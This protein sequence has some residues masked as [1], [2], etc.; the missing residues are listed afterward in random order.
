MAARG[1]R[2]RAAVLQEDPDHPTPGRRALTASGIPVL[3]F[4]PAGSVAA[5]DNVA[6]LLGYVDDDPPAAILL[7][8]VIPVYRV[9]IADGLFDVP[10]FDVSPGAMSFDALERY[11]ERPRPELPY[12][13]AGDYAARLKAA[14]VKYPAEAARAAA[15]L[16]CPVHVIPNGVPINAT[17]RRP[18][19]ARIVIGTVARIHPTKRL[20]LL[21]DAMKRAHRSLPPYVLRIAGG[22]DGDCHDYAADLRRQSECLPI[23]WLGVAEDVAAF[24]GD[25]DLFVLVAEPAG[26]PNASLEAMA[27]GLPVVATD[28]GGMAEQVEPGVTGLLVGRDDVEGLAAAVLEAASDPIRHIAWGEA[29]RSRAAERFSLERMVAHYARVCLGS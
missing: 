5:A 19:G 18:P 10:L 23:E 6:R 12:R 4:P 28:A 25:L 17:P 24:L 29:A 11:F 14:I 8:N 26:C 27:A 9:L 3:A 13:S 22:V 1:V 16:R 20:D 15:M 2:T 7:W 21:I